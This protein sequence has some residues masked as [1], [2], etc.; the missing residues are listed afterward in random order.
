MQEIPSVPARG[1]LLEMLHDRAHFVRTETMRLVAIAKSGHYS[2]VFSCAELF[3]ALY[4]YWLRIDPANPAWPDR[5]RFILGKGHAAV[6]LYPVLA[7][8]GFFDPAELNNYTR[9]GSPFGDHPDMRH[10]RGVDFSSGSLGHGL[11]VAVG[12]GLS[13]RDAGRD[14][15]VVCMLGDAELNEGQIW[16]AAMAAS[17]FSL[18]NVIAIVDRNGMGLDGFTEEVTA[19]EP[20][21]D[22]WRAFGWNV[23]EVDGHDVQAVVDTLDQ[24]GRPGSTGRPTALIAHTVK[25]WGIEWMEHSR[26]WHLG[27]LVNEDLADAY[28]ALERGMNADPPRIQGRVRTAPPTE[29]PLRARGSWSLRS[30]PAPT[31][32]HGQELAELGAVDDRIVVLSADLG[33]SGRTI[34]FADKFPD[35]FFN[36]GVAEQNMMTVAAGLA[37]D[38]MIPYAG[39]FASYASLLSAEQLRTDI[40]YPGLPVRILA[41]H[42]G[43]SLG[44]YGTS[45]HA[46]EDLGITR[47]IAGLDVVAATDE[48]M[49][50]AILRFSVHHPG[51]LYIR[52][53]RGRDETVYD[54][55]P[56]FELG[57]SWTLRDGSDISLLA[58]G[59]TVH[60]TLRAAEILDRAGIS[61]RVIDLASIDPLDTAIVLNAASE[62]GAIMTVE[63][64]NVTG[65]IGSAVSEVLAEAGVSIAFQR[66]GIR[67]EY[68]LVG[69]P[70][71]LYAHYQ[72][73]AS[74]IADVARRFLLGAAGAR[75]ALQLL[76]SGL[77]PHCISACCIAGVMTA[78]G[79]LDRGPGSRLVADPGSNPY[80]YNDGAGSTPAAPVRAG[81]PRRATGQ[82]Q[83]WRGRW[84]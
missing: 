71:G 3:A 6:G 77:W 35:R 50:R 74:G 73:D 54:T 10:V 59:S 82:R 72:L 13:A 9:V 41:H 49:L 30:R 75:R 81:L 22:K 20:L 24:I 46:L 8:L 83:P 79:T 31:F 23:L 53:G 26:E 57:R 42:S 44:F 2:S 78:D 67:N 84:P 65:G 29:K 5:D 11:S 58:T 17:H 14:N 70:A 37:A 45:H 7:D 60:A 15:R 16:E 56:E 76:P 63:E 80:G 28:A 38:G 27:A 19:I 40:A 47:S 43:M 66:H 1:E 39:T 62:C 69:P 68:V 61:A 52:M 51:P 55:V 32:I 48:N 12:M 18:G 21:A 25:G 64:H 34:E 36:V 33:Y 4:Y